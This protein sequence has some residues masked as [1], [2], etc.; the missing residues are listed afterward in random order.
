[1]V[2]KAD[3]V[4]AQSF[5]RRRLVTALV[6]GAGG[7]GPGRSARTLV[8]GLALAVLVVAGAVIANVVAPR[9]PADWTSHGLILSEQTG[10]AYVIVGDG[11]PSAEPGSVVLR[12][13]AN[14]TSARLVLGPGAEPVSVPQ[15]L[16]ETQPIGADIGILGAP[17]SLPPPDRLVESGWTACTADRRGTRVS[18]VAD[19]D[20]EPARD[21]GQVV[22][23]GGGSAMP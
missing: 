17:A 1:M 13:V 22:A 21:A 18:V 19:P 16:I 12:P 23:V 14:L 7:A 8:G 15:D 6:S 20:V 2:T 11:S 10:Q 3:L 9:P 5:D 4:E